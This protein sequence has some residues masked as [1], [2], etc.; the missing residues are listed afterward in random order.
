MH[1]AKYLWTWSN[2]PKLARVV[3]ACHLAL[4]R[5]N[6]EDDLSRASLG[7][8]AKTCLKDKGKKTNKKT[9]KWTKRKSITNCLFLL[10]IRGWRMGSKIRETLE[11]LLCEGGALVPE[12][13]SPALGWCASPWV[14]WV[15]LDFCST[16]SQALLENQGQYLAL[17]P[18]P[19][20]TQV[21]WSGHVLGLRS[22]FRW[23]G[24]FSPSLLR[25]RATGGR[26]LR[27]LPSSC[28]LFT[29]SLSLYF[30]WALTWRSVMAEM[31][32]AQRT[33]S[34]RKW[35]SWSCT[36]SLMTGSWTMT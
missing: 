30:K 27:D 28:L 12:H 6:L 21:R 17:F 18:L 4:W 20:C 15:F 9:S 10:E 14:S 1:L 7:Y 33:W 8:I 2:F 24:P 16:I 3:H 11:T 13:T 19:W 5:M 29:L 36:Q 31:T 26:V 34:M 25:L 22:A 32:S 23:T 35:T